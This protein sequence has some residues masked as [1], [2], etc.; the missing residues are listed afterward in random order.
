ML[1][2]P[3]NIKVHFAATENTRQLVAARAMGVNYG[4]FTAAPFIVQKVIPNA[5]LPIF[6]LPHMKGGD[7]AK[8]IPKEV[9]QS[10]SHTIQDSGLF[11]LMFNLTDI[12]ERHFAK[13]YDA[14]VE[15]T[16]AH[17]QQCTVVE[18]DC[19]KLFGAEKAWEY[20]ERMRRDLPNHRQIN[21]FHQPDGKYGL[22]RL[23]E[24]SDY[25]ALPA[26]EMRRMGKTSHLI[27][28][29]NYVKQ[30]KP[31]IDIHLLGCTD[32]KLLHQCRYCTSSDSTSYVSGLRYGFIS[33]HH[34]SKIITNK[35][36]KLV[37]DNIYNTIRRFYNE[38][39]TNCLCLQIGT[40]ML[41]YEKTVGNQDYTHRPFINT[42]NKK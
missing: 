23:I 2:L 32:L 7:P 36:K 5:K 28:L 42:N 3:D 11:T 9:C 8:L 22:D 16:L 31:T 21:V 29:V 27:K 15:F 24:F 6:M 30:R 39:N 33:G 34:T 13:W 25:I 4:L 14:L 26:T 12:S 41:K 19:Q 35:V 20:R 10:F 18:C 37:G 1:H 17:G 40:L 38:N